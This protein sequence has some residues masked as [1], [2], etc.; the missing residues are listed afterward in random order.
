[1]LPNQI[2]LLTGATGGIGQAIAHCFDTQGVKL[3]LHGRNEQQLKTLNESLSG[4][5]HIVLGDLT[6]ERSRKTLIKEAFS[7]SLYLPNILINNA[8]VSQFKAFENVDTSDIEH[9]ISMNLSA[10]IDFTQLFLQETK[11]PS[12][13]VN[14]G[15]A[16]GSIGYPGYTLYC[17]TKFGLR[18]FTEALN[19]ELADSEHRVCYFAPRATN[20][21]F[22]S[23]NAEQM[24][25]ELGNH[26]DSPDFVARQLFGLI[27]S[28]GAR[29][30]VGWP[31]KL[32][33]RL[34]GLF[35][36]LVDKAITKHTSKIITFAKGEQR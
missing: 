35:P 34:N 1:M 33:T 16:F 21:A 13:I 18:G 10:T 8:G 9:L 29:K 11:Q 28:N 31:E 24:N 14:I 6:N 27:N 22:N 3:I 19:R 25:S 17:A 32:F 23:K 5:H 7:D 26:S 30:T 15:S 36:E 12:T 2:V 4:G 20:T